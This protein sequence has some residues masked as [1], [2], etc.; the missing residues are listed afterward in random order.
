MRDG[1]RAQAAI[2]VLD[3]LAARPAP[4][5]TSSVSISRAGAIS[6]RRTAP[7][8][9]GWSTACCAGAPSSTGG[10]SGPAR[11]PTRACAS[12]PGWRWRKGGRWTSSTKASTRRRSGRRAWT[13][14]S[15]Q[16]R[17]RW[18]ARR[19]TIREQPPSVRR[20]YPAWIEPALRERFGADL[21]AE[22]TALAEPAPLDL[23][24]NVLKT[25]REAALH[26]L[27]AAGLEVEPTP[28]VAARHPG[29]GPTAARH[30]GTVPRR[31]RRGAGRR[32]AARRPAGRGARPACGSS[33]SA[34]V[35]AASRSPWPPP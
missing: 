11:R 31:P 12:S 14:R 25:T 30:A 19:S 8:S 7:P 27:A 3:E 22:M 16:R 6:A 20:N 4:A 1:A 34:P 2:E 5:D 33:I 32:L 24:A 15:A 13:R 21:D 10:W 18:P 17:R 26:A 23:R 28:L 9:P 35:P 29:R